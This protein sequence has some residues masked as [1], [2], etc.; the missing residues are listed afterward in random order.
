MVGGSCI[1]WNSGDMVGAAFGVGSDIL[2]LC[3]PLHAVWKL[4]IP[5]K[6]KIGVSAFFMVGLL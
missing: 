6:R 3:M 1:S 2:L 5:R 4:Q